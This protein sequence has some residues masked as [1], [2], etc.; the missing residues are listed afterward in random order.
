MKR[1]TMVLKVEEASRKLEDA[2]NLLEDVLD[3]DPGN[4]ALWEIVDRI[5]LESLADL[6]RQALKRILH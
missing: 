5:E 1:A 3:E 4:Q 6:W 2:V